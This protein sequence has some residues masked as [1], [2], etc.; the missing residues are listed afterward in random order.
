MPYKFC[1]LLVNNPKRRMR[2]KIFSP[3]PIVIG[4]ISVIIIIIII[5][6]IIAVIISIVSAP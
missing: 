3:N 1:Y 4:I 5:V 2:N 6:I